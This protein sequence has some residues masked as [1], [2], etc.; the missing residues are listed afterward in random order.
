MKT[1]NRKFR[2]NCELK[3][4][5]KAISILK[6][7]F[8]VEDISNKEIYKLADGKTLP[9][10]VKSNKCKKDKELKEKILSKYEN[11]MRRLN[12]FSKMQSILREYLVIGNSFN[13]LEWDEDNKEW[14]KMIQ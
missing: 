5:R 1:R 4:F 3:K 14:S 13:F 7:V 11:V 12:L 2:T 8:K 10:E 9:K 6:N